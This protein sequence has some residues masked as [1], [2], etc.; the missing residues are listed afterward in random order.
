MNGKIRLNRWLKG[1]LAYLLGAAA[2]VGFFVWGVVIGFRAAEDL[3]LRWRSIA[4]TEEPEVCA[5]CAGKD[6]LPSAG[7]WLADLHSGQLR[8]LTNWAVTPEK[9]EPMEPALFCMDCRRLLARRQTEGVVLLVSNGEGLPLVYA[10]KAGN[11]YE[12]SCGVVSVK[13]GSDRNTLT[14][15]VVTR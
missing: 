11:E 10:V 9:P 5:L 6:T 7:L 12:L 4:L 1:S 15:E 3:T 2:C 8:L 14:V 13:R